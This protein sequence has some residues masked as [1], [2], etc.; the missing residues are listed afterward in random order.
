MT[1]PPPY[2]RDGLLVRF[3][4]HTG[5]QSPDT[6]LGVVDKAE[7]FVGIGEGEYACR[8]PV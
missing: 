3:H 6:Q 7:Q 8:V 4:I 5:G 1:L 2:L